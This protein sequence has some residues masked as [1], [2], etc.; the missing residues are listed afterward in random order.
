M[1]LWTSWFPSV[2][3]KFALEIDKLNFHDKYAVATTL[4][5]DGH[6]ASGKPLLT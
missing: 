3:D 1:R 2:G 6:A 5:V 4:K